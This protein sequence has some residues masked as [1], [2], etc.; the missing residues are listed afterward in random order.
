MVCQTYPVLAKPTNNETNKERIWMLL[1]K[2]DI[3]HLIDHVF[4]DLLPAIG[5]AERPEQ[6]ALS[7]RMLEA[8]LTDSIALCDAGTG[9]GKTYAY[10]TAGIAF[11]KWREAGKQHFQPII[12]STSSIALQRAI[13]SD[14][15]P[16]LSDL[17][18]S[19]GI[20]DQPVAAVMRKGKQHYVCDKRLEH[21]LKK[22]D[23]EKKNK[24]AANALMSL[25]T[26]FDLDSV[27]HL[28]SYDKERVCVPQVCDCRV[29]GC[30][31]RAFLR[32]CTWK[33]FAF[34]ICNHNLLLADAMQREAGQRPILPNSCAVIIDEAHKLPET[35]RQM[36]GVTLD[37]EDLTHL[38]RDL[39][40]ERYYLASDYLRSASKRLIEELEAP[41]EN[42]PFA[43]YAH[44]LVGPDRVLSVIGKQIGSRLSPPA[45]KHLHD[46]SAAAS[47]LCSDQ[48]DMI[49]YTTESESGGTALCATVTNLSDR[50][51]DTLWRQP[52]PALLTSG[53][54]AAG[55]SFHRFRE[56]T[57]LTNGYQIMESVSPSPFDY[58]R[59][60]L[61][62]LPKGSGETK[63]IDTPEY[64][65]RLTA[66]MSALVTASCGHALVLFN[67]YIAMSAIKERLTRRKLPWTLYTMSRNA[68]YTVEQ[69]KA[70]PGSILLATGA[71]WEGFDFPGDCVSMLIIP[72]L[73]F[74]Y[75]D[76]VKEKEREEYDSL[77][78]FIRSV[79]VPEMQIK[80]R[81]GFGR[82]IRTDTDT[83]VVAILD[84]RAS[85]GKRYYHDVI[86][87]LPS[88]RQTC[89]ITEVDWF[90]RS[91][92][93]P[94]YFRH[95]P[96]MKKEA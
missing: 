46:I 62:Y 87:A 44:L 23:M 66:E 22:V 36:F 32:E 93:A 19:D 79:V 34:H 49:F 92:K 35:A 53:T 38:S 43:Y 24:A 82:A 57:G 64:Y 20:L 52:R 31:Y 12:I 90:I 59:N 81:Q 84:E 26:C 39:R 71:A 25:T 76:A 2:Q 74:P 51:Q 88:M 40:K 95:V 9:I 15:L 30:R 28:S 55:S 47:T 10:L 17:M 8:M 77:H 94:G 80:L 21:R 29:S 83:C 63:N 69:F 37:A 48:T 86:Q 11:Q 96:A 61:M 42:H 4:K 91:V 50:L 68:V 14:Y 60:C 70:H 7:H 6:I 89:D 13:L 45:A 1:K 5:M 56:E 33:R 41:R 16:L 58:K 3:H 67:S 75:P 85:L 27:E 65:D 72:R 73:P 18:Q 54:L 78:S